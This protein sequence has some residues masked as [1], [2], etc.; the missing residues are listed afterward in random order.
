MA[1]E[2]S[3]LAKLGFYVELKEGFRKEIRNRIAEKF[4]SLRDFA[5][6]VGLGGIT[7]PDVLNG[8]ESAELSTWL[9]ISDVLGVNTEEFKKNILKIKSRNGKAFLKSEKLP[10]L[11]S[12]KL[13][14]LVGHGLGDG[15]VSKEGCFEYTNGDLSLQERVLSIISKLFGSYKYSEYKWKVKRRRF[16]TIVGKILHLAGVPRGNKIMQPFSVPQWILNGSTEIKKS[17]IRALFDDEGTIKKREILIKFSKNER[18]I[19]SLQKFMEQ[20]RQIL[21]DLGIEVT[22]IGKENI[23]IGKNG[24]TIQLVLGIHGYKNFMRFL[25]EIKFNHKQKQKKLE[26]MINNYKSFQNKK[27]KTQ[28][29]L[30]ENLSKPLTI[31]ELINR[32]NMSYVKVYKGLRKLERK[33]LIKRIGYNK[34]QFIIWGKHND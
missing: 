29:I 16:N 8:K 10:I 23:V 3:E 9:K 20:I 15:H 7:L 34:N 26:E 14:S 4:S 5:S 1:I 11:L 13:A 2:I 24:R 32:L 30:Y 19:D 33:G 27:G 17:F 18:Y 6:Q 31:S 25:K 21:E 12:A 22:S 28:K